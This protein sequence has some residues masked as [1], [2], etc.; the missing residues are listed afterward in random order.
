MRDFS[1]SY[2]LIGAMRYIFLL[3]VLSLIINMMQDEFTVSAIDITFRNP[4]GM[5][6]ALIIFYLD[7]K[8]YGAIEKAK[9]KRNNKE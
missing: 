8:K 7:G 1:V 3:L 6:F 2:G 9:S 5:I 4:F